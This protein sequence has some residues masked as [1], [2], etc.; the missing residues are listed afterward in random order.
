MAEAERA[1]QEGNLELCNDLRRV[2]AIARGVPMLRDE[3]TKLNARLYDK[4]AA[5]EG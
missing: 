4:E 2:V 5:N 1:R 3:I